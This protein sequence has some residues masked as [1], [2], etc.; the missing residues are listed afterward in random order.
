[1]RILPSPWGFRGVRQ[2]PFSINL[3]VVVVHMIVLL[4]AVSAPT[5]Q[6][7]TWRAD[8]QRIFVAKRT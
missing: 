1:M 5:T 3:E 4:V 8:D 7:E 6:D 2:R